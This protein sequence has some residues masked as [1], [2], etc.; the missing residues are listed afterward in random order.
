MVNFYVLR[1]RI[2]INAL[3]DLMA[4]DYIVKSVSELYKRCSDC[5]ALIISRDIRTHFI[6]LA[7]LGIILMF[8]L[9]KLRIFVLK[10]LMNI[11]NAHAIV[12]STN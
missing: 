8:F 5:N 3:G 6:A 12:I 11:P 9:R 7:L 1:S 4:C 10:T 2:L